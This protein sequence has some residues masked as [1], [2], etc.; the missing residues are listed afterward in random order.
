MKGHHG[1]R[2]R[3]DHHPPLQ[4]ARWPGGQSHLSSRQNLCLRQRT[5][6]DQRRAKCGSKALDQFV[7]SL[8]YRVA[9][10][11]TLATDSFVCLQWTVAW[12]DYSATLTAQKPRRRSSLLKH[13]ILIS[14]YDLL[15]IR[16]GRAFPEG[17]FLGD[18]TRIRGCTSLVLVVPQLS[19][20]LCLHFRRG[21][22][23][24]PVRQ[25]APAVS[26]PPTHFWHPG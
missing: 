2:G 25:T 11:A 13:N 26:Q 5:P 12:G 19:G 14:L 20:H 15:Y 16:R 1:H 18:K 24:A 23:A 3:S 7:I 17:P 10:A 6:F 9:T 4:V 22:R 8:R 21:G